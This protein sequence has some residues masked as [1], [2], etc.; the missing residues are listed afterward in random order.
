[1]ASELRFVFKSSEAAP[2]L[3]NNLAI[4]TD[5]FIRFEYGFCKHGNKLDRY[6]KL[7]QNAITVRGA[8][9]TLDERHC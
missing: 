4:R 9:N 1:M 8:T 5:W 3:A 2:V 7:K 6:Q